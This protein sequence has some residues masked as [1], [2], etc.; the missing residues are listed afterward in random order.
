[1]LALWGVFPN[2]ES[3][4][5]RACCNMAARSFDSP[6]RF[7]LREREQFVGS[8]K[9]ALAKARRHDRF[10]GFQFLGRVSPNVNFRG[11]QT[12]VPQP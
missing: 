3:G 9:L 7:P 5:G 11:G 8:P 12:A 4:I 1:M 2:G 6:L 10:D